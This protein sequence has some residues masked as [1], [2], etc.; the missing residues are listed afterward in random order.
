MEKIIVRVTEVG[1]T[2]ASISVEEGATVKTCLEKINVSTEAKQITVN[3][4]EKSLETIVCNEDTIYV[5]PQVKGN[6]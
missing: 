3:G 5:I 1:G 6:R 2:Q 4:V